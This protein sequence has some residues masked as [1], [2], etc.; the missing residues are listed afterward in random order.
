MLEQLLQTRFWHLS[1]SF[2]DQVLPI[3]LT[4]IEQGKDLSIFQREDPVRSLNGNIVMAAKDIFSFRTMINDKGERVALIPLYGTMNKYGGMCS[5]GTAE[6]AN[7]IA[8]ANRNQN[9]IKSILIDLDTP[10]GASNSVEV[11]DRAIASSELPI[12]GW[13][14]GMACSAGQWVASSIARKGRVMVDSLTN[15]TMGSIGAFTI[16][17]N[18][19]ARLLASGVKVEIIRAPQSK[20]KARFNNLEEITQELR[21]ELEQELRQLVDDFKAEVSANY[22][23]K[24]KDD[25]PKLWTGGTFNGKQSL[26]I[27]LAHEQG[28]L[29]D[30][31]EMVLDLAHT[32][33]KQSFSFNSNTDKDM[34]FLK[35]LGLSISIAQKLSAEELENLG[36]AEERL[37]EMES[38]NAQLTEANGAFTTQVEELTA[39]LEEA[40]G[41]ISTHETTIQE[42][43]ARITELEAGPAA[44]ATTVVADGDPQADASSQAIIDA[45]P[46]N[47]AI[48]ANPMFNQSPKQEEK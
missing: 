43:D 45:L 5:L 42:R 24:L 16:H 41:T 22:G 44:P 30:A 9:K 33:K 18:V 29:T 32:Q 15:S 26:E 20:D 7:M 27:G 37:A 1:E 2:L 11:L 28:Q 40:N 36:A 17:Q 38:A 3:A 10:G 39:S 14:D 35:R 12:G 46:H 13:V 31:F 4:R 8:E 25:F 23:G 6:L 34:S 47:K 21:T 19:M 48:D